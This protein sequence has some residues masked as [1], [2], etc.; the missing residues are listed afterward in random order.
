MFPP[1]GQFTHSKSATK[2]NEFLSTINTNEGYAASNRFEVLVLPPTAMAFEVQSKDISLR[3]I[4]VTLPGRNLATLTDS[5]IYGPTREIVNG[6]T[7]AEDIS[8][9]FIASAGLRER[10][11]FEEWQ[12]LAFNDSTWDLGYYDDYVGDIEIYILNRQNERKFGIKL[13]EVFPK[14]IGGTELTM[15][16]QNA[17]ITLPITFAFHYWETLDINR[18]PDRA[19]AENSVGG[20][21]TTTTTLSSRTMHTVNGEIHDGHAHAVV[22]YP[23]RITGN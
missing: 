18:V 7:Y 12:Q 13:I 5:N 23:P 6:V 9:T 14:T 11:F 1:E 20:T 22:K 10:V 21:T 8:L 15:E 3:C 16:T 19:T 17:I 4:D 2:L